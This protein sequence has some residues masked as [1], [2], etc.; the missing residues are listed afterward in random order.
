MNEQRCQLFRT[1]QNSVV[2]TANNVV[3]QYVS[4]YYDI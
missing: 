3:V 1:M 2:V 4:L